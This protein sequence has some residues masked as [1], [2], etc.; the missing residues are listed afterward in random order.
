MQG[1]LPELS[2]RSLLQAAGVAAFLSA[3]HIPL[4]PAKAAE[5]A[6]SVRLTPKM[7]DGWHYGHCHMCMRRSC[8]NLYR[9]QNGIAVEVMGN[10]KCPTTKGALCAKGQAI[11]QNTY[12]PYRVKAPMKRTNPEKGMD[13]DP[14]WVEITWEE[15]MST[16]ASRFKEIYE[17]DPRRLLY[18]VGFGDMDFFCTFMFYFAQ[19]F[20]TPN[21]VK[22][23]G[24]LCTLHYA[25]DLVQ[26][27]FP[28]AV[29]D[30]T[31][32]RYC[33]A[34]G[35]SMGMSNA[36]SEGGTRGM[37]DLMYKGDKDFRLVVIDPRCSPEASKGEW[38][39]IRPGGDLA[40]LMAVVHC[41]L[42]EIKMIDEHFL[43]WRTNAPYLIAPD[44]NYAR[45][46][47][48]KPQI[49]DAA[50]GQ[51]KSFDDK[52]LKDP[53]IWCTG[54]DVNG[55]RADAAMVLVK[56]GFEKNTPE[57]AEKICDVPAKTI[58][59]VARDYIMNAR[60]GETVTLKNSKGED[61]VMPVRAAAFEGKRG[62]KNQRD[63]VPCDLMCKMLTMLIGGIDVPGGCVAKARSAFHL[64]PDKDGVV[65]P[66]GEA[67]DNPMSYPPKHINLSDYFPHK[68]TL[69]ILAYKVAQNPKK[70]GFDYELEAS[71][72]CGSNPIASTS[73]PEE[74]IKGVKK[75]PFAVNIAYHYDEMAQMSDILLASHSV[76]ER[77]SVNVW[78]AA[79]DLSTS[80]TNA[81]RFAMYRDP[82]PPIYNTRQ[83]QDIIMDLCERM[84]LIDK[85]NANLNKV[86][87]VLGEVTTAMLKPENQ[88]EPGRRYTIQEIWD[89][90]VKEAFGGKGLQYLKENGLI[91]EPRSTAEAYNAYW[92]K[93]GETR[94]PIYFEKTKASGDRQRA[95]FEKYKDKIYL[96]DFDPKENLKYYEPVIQWR[97]KPMLE[98]KDTD[99][100]PLLA[101]NF[102]TA[103]SPSR[104]GAT[105]QMPWLEEIGETFDPQYGTICINPRTAE[106]YGIKEGDVI[107]MESVNG[108]TRGPVHLSELF[109]PGTVNVGGS[110]GRL[111][112]SLGTKPFERP[113]YNHLCNG[114]PSTSD[115]F[116]MG[117]ENNVAVKIYKAKTGKVIEGVCVC[118]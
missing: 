115:P 62:I 50:D 77:E 88:L 67:R 80:E 31:Y 110:L 71:L 65:A 5:E 35:M 94:H 79:F 23:N 28:G 75:I 56:K 8:P 15:A 104:C 106:K 11:I 46:A 47:D 70:Y 97:S 3:L 92:Y 26:G 48:G 118:D 41:V 10:P 25:S 111:V 4:D 32:N 109:R 60:I 33:V 108:R 55:V 36:A 81:L 59:K 63:G 89:R 82:L 112:K 24:I 17:R 83:P 117:V 44:G 20:G 101:I 53:D 40:F 105:D 113:M 34:A 58:R 27:V 61:V 7:K 84:G 68:H 16:V 64:R 49:R 29:Q 21:F 38:I 99:E 45:G 19:T 103:L 13:V 86:G 69:P 85:F 42:F 107:W 14:K 2:R 30:A 76:L 98:I 96:P 9:V 52:T 66:K 93:D 37:F 51:I 72:T 57:W 22:S 1:R 74:I 95:F 116:Q 6:K 43:K 78:E 100:Y 87:V 39:P 114:K 102:K 73:E 54:Q 12:N 91:V 90:G 18:Q